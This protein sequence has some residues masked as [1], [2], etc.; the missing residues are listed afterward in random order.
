M[1]FI[2]VIWWPSNFRFVPLSC[3]FTDG[4]L[5]PLL[6]WH[7]LHCCGLSVN[8]FLF[9]MF[10]KLLKSFS[11]ADGFP[12]AFNCSGLISFLSFYWCLWL[13]GVK[14][15]PSLPYELKDIFK[16]DVGIKCPLFL[17]QFWVFWLLWTYLKLLS[18]V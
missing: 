4:Q 7:S 14:D 6:Q 5:S 15:I 12:I 8:R 9:S 2:A 13:E 3:H 11:S 18:W 16:K 1:I 17:H 10:Q